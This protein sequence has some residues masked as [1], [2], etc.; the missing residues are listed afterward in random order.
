M[1]VVKRVV[2]VWECQLDCP[3]REGL[4]PSAL[5]NLEGDSI[6]L[7]GASGESR[8]GTAH[9]KAWRRGD[10][11]VPERG[12]YYSERGKGKLMGDTTNG[13]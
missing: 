11:S 5:A 13:G 4:H 8:G 10:R 2:M 9:S 6:G 3:L 7:E 1:S 12:C